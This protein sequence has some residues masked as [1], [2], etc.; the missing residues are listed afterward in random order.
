[1]DT[2]A[3]TQMNMKAAP[4]MDFDSAPWLNMGAVTERNIPG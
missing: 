4:Q 2:I 1:M 3:V